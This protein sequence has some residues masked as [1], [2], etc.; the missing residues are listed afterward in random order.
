MIKTETEMDFD[1]AVI[2]HLFT[3]LNYGRW[4][5]LVIKI[6]MFFNETGYF[7]ESIYRLCLIYAFKICK[8]AI[9]LQMDITN[10]IKPFIMG[11]CWDFDHHIELAE[12]S[13]N[14]GTN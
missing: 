5:R 9:E 6:K 8:K 2:Q 10:Y 14:T 7:S 3:L 11:S 12:L 1:V 13:N 4:L